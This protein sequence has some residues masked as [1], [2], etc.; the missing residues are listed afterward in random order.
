MLG[1]LDEL[2]AKGSKLA[3][4]D[5]GKTF[6]GASF[7]ADLRNGVDAIGRMRAGLDGLRAAGGERIISPEEIATARQIKAEIDEI[8]N[9]LAAAMKPVME[10]ITKIQLQMLEGWTSSKLFIIQNI[11][12]LHNF[13][14]L[15]D[16]R[17]VA[18]R[19]GSRRLWH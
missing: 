15:H 3:V 5:L 1:L 18:A 13:R 16:R 4:F 19:G 10:Q 14:A 6:F 12:A 17:L 11:R 2:I 9:R 8:N 7:E